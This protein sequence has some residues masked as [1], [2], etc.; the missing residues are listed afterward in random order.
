MHTS[1]YTYI[2]THAKQSKRGQFKSSVSARRERHCWHITACVPTVGFWSRKV[3]K[4]F[5]QNWNH[6]A[7]TLPALIFPWN[8]I[9]FCYNSTF[10]LPEVNNRLWGLLSHSAN[11][12]L[13]LEASSLHTILS[14]PRIFSAL[15][16]YC[17][18]S[19]P[20]LALSELWLA[21]QPS[22]SDSNYSPSWLIQSGFSQFLLNSSA[23]PHTN[24][25]NMF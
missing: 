5:K 1:R 8:L 24:S 20:F 13:V 4:D 2:R 14:R 21:D 25:R 3:P 12:G 18:I 9:I 22:Y 10:Y 16:T 15:R 11:I 7:I 23:C 17:W 6:A 19:S